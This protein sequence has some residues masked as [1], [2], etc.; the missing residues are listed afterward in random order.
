MSYSQRCDEKRVAMRE[1]RPSL[2]AS[3]VE[4]GS[5]YW[6][7][8]EGREWERGRGWEKR[9]RERERAGIHVSQTWPLSIVMLTT[10][11]WET[12][13]V[14]IYSWGRRTM[15][16]KRTNIRL[17]QTFCAFNFRGLPWLTEIF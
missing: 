14:K 16:I 2:R 4:K 9:G 7:G 17:R 8:R 13:V 12:F 3:L 10:A 11:I 1:M 6:R 5:Q 15:K